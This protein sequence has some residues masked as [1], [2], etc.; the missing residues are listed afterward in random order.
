M[1]TRIAKKYRR[2][3][4]DDHAI[5]K[6]ANK[7]IQP[8]LFFE[9]AELLQVNKNVL[10][11]HVFDVSLKTL[12]R[13][14]KHDKPLNPR[15]SEIALKLLSLFNKGVEIF[16]EGTAFMAWMYKPAFGLGDQ[17]PFEIINTNTGMDL[18][19]EELFRIEYGVLA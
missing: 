18:V 3:I 9:L 5:L 13:Y 4:K 14:A 6:N 15:Q 8:D 19:E 16:G 2:A 17:I 10:A 1:S 11:E 7:G 12:Q